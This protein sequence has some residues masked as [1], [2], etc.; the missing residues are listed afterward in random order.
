[1]KKYSRII[2]LVV[3]IALAIIWYSMSKSPIGTDSVAN[4]AT[5]TEYLADVKK[6]IM[7]PEEDPTFLV[8][9]NA[10]LISKQQAFFKDVVNGDALFVFP[11]AGKAIIWSPSR[12]MVINS[13]PIEYT[14]DPKSTT[15][16]P[17]VS[18]QAR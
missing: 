10:E 14:P 7:V 8:V 15:T 4:D 12:D 17:V 1:M 13:G 16:K 9:D 2:A 6:V 3:I 11:T 5:K 18:N